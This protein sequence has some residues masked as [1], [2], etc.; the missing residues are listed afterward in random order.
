MHADHVWTTD[1]KVI[2]RYPDGK[3][4]YE[5]D[6]VQAAAAASNK[7][8]AQKKKA[9]VAQTKIHLDRVFSLQP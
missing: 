8:A 9:E 4:Y 1:E 2:C 5:G 7:A 6:T 3:L